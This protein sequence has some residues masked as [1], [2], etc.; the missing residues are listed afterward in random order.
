LA[1]HA[2]ILFTV[3]DAYRPYLIFDRSK[4][5]GPLNSTNAAS[6]ERTSRFFYLPNEF[7]KGQVICN[8]RHSDI[9]WSRDG[10]VQFIRRSSTGQHVIAVFEALLENI[11]ETQRQSIEAMPYV[12]LRLD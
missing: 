7:I 1:L 8:H 4:S 6:C 11:E 5:T 12:G 9:Q 2:V 10:G 3:R